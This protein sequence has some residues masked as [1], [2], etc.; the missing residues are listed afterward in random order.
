LEA[1]KKD[2]ERID[3]PPGGCPEWL[4]RTVDMT[5]VRKEIGPRIENGRVGTAD[6][7]MHKKCVDSTGF[8]ARGRAIRKARIAV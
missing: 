5:N 2:L 4:Q 1:P 6:R 8:F 7:I 3:S